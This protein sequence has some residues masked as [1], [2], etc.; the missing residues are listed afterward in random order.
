[1]TLY[2]TSFLPPVSIGMDHSKKTL[3]SLTLEI[4]LRGADGGP[5]GD[6]KGLEEDTAR[7]TKKHLDKQKP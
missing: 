1:M 4:A 7:N 5:E 6:E 3:V 2:R